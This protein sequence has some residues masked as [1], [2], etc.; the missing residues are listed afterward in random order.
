MQEKKTGKTVPIFFSLISQSLLITVLLPDIHH[1]AILQRT[2][3]IPCIVQVQ[4]HFAK[5]VCRNAKA[6]WT[7]TVSPDFN[8]S[9]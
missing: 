3:G 1:P 9:M 6:A 2:L 4:I 5:L 8:V 7:V